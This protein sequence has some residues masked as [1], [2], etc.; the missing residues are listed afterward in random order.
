M[1]AS[2]VWPRLDAVVFSCC[3]LPEMLH[4]TAGGPGGMLGTGTAVGHGEGGGGCGTAQCRGGGT[5]TWEAFLTRYAAS[6]A[7][8]FTPRAG[9][10]ATLER[11]YARHRRLVSL[12]EQ[13]AGAGA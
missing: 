5:A 1:Y 11:S 10:A 2:A 8:R 6:P 13:F 3:Q 4:E 12:H 7:H 9:S